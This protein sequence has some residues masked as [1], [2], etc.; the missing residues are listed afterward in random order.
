M[1][2]VVKMVRV[3]VFCIVTTIRAHVLY[4]NSGTCTCFRVVIVACKEK[5]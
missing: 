4:C 5:S 3:Y 2:C 1:F